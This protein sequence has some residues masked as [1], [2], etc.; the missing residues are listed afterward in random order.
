[1]ACRGIVALKHSAHAAGRA[2]DAS[3]SSDAA[4]AS[5][6]QRACGALLADIESGKQPRLHHV[7]RVI[8]VQTTCR[9]QREALQA[10]GAWLAGLAAADTPP[11]SVAAAEGSE[12]RTVR[13][14][15]FL[16][17]R[18]AAGVKADAA[19]GGVPA[20]P[21]AEAAAAPEA[22]A[23]AAPEAAPLDRGAI[24]ASLAAGFEQGLRWQH[25]LQAAVDLKAPDFVLVA[26]VVPSAG[27]LYAALCIL[28]SAL[29]LLKPKLHIKPVGKL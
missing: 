5:L 6:V 29:C 1:M 24:I 10:A 17:Q 27:D 2:V 22:A 12:A 4:A 19:E 15:I 16:K 18:E 21:E 7:Q 11:A 3:S 26:E 25:G 23:N 13:F 20:P 14:G 28:P 8:P 9:V